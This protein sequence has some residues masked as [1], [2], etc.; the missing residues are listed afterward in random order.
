MW[1]TEIWERGT[2]A[3]R[4]LVLAE[5]KC[6]WKLETWLQWEWKVWR[7]LR[8]ILS[9]CYLEIRFPINLLVQVSIISVRTM[10]FKWVSMVQFPITAFTMQFNGAL[11]ESASKLRIQN[12]YALLKFIT[13]KHPNRNVQSRIIWWNVLEKFIEVVPFYV[14][15]FGT[16][17]E[18]WEGF[19]K[20]LCLKSPVA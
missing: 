12:I 8:S 19:Q 9:V 3:K 11:H 4:K 13:E 10:K 6:S 1:K 15:K 2:P 20:Q 16:A 5:C 18:G 14:Y 7:T 17:F